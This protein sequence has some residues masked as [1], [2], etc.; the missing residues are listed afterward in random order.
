MGVPF[1][2]GAKVR[3]QAARQVGDRLWVESAV[4]EPLEHPADHLHIDVR[5][6]KNPAF[7]SV[8]QQSATHRHRVTVTTIGTAANEGASSEPAKRGSVTIRVLR[9][10]GDPARGARVRIG[11]QLVASNEKGLAVFDS[12]PIG[13]HDLLVSQPGLFSIRRRIDVEA[14]KESRLE[15]VEPLGGTVEVLVVDDRGK[16]LPYASLSVRTASG[17]LWLDLEGTTQ[18][19]D[20]YTDRGGRRVL[21]NL[22]PGRIRVQASWGGRAGSAA[23]DVAQNSEGLIRVVVGLRDG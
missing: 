20:P 23:V 4:S 12:L 2:P 17:D 6:P 19:V 8:S 11:P 13:E 3:V 7:L 21:H 1:L 5:L 18:R 22:E 16:A 10:N 14:N 15:L 9:R